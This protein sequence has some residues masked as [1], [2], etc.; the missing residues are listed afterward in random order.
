MVGGVSDVRTCNDFYMPVMLLFK[1]CFYRVMRVGYSTFLL[2]L[3]HL[4]ATSSMGNTNRNIILHM[5]YT[6]R[7]CLKA[8]LSLDL[9]PSDL[10]GPGM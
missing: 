7:K 6:A 5:A 2:L 3:Y 4:Y 9:R 10:G 1:L 8:P